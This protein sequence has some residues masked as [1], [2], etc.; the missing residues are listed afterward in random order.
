LE[1]QKR[2]DELT[3]NI[4]ASI[5]TMSDKVEGKHFEEKVI[6]QHNF[7]KRAIKLKKVI[8]QVYDCQNF[9]KSKARCM[10]KSCLVRD[11][12]L[13]E[14]HGPAHDRH[15]SVTEWKHENAMI[16]TKA[17]AGTSSLKVIVE[18]SIVLY[19]VLLVYSTVLI[20]YLLLQD[21]HTLLY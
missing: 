2:S 15:E 9:I 12:F 17:P 14:S 4:M 18:Y 21:H 7:S 16:N 19:V 11:K 8:C 20:Y 6:L 5:K 1:R 10:K 3:A 13:C